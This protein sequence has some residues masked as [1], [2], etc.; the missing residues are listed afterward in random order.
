MKNY[1]KLYC[2]KGNYDL[3]CEPLGTEGRHI[4]NDLQTIRGAKNRLIKWYNYNHFRIYTYSNFYDDK[5]FRLI[6]EQ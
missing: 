4:F 5:T 3:G 2:Y 6:Y 1:L